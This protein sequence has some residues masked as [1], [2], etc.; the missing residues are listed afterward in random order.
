MRCCTH[1]PPSYF[2]L[3][4]KQDNAVRLYSLTKGGKRAATIADLSGPA[5][6]V[7]FNADGS[8]IVAGTES[9]DLRLL[10]MRSGEQVRYFSKVA[11][12]V[13]SR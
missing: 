12:V 13:I 3:P 2:G 4:H 6:A 8:L 5:T 1:N 7:A 10:D 9:G 11:Q